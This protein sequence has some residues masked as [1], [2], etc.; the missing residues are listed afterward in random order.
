LGRR[1]A[2]PSAWQP[3]E[4]APKDG[5][6]ILI[7]TPT[8]IVEAWF[9]KGQ[10][11]E[12]TPYSEAEYEGAVWVCYDDKF[13]IEIEESET[14]Y[15]SEAT[16]WDAHSGLGDQMNFSQLLQEASLVDPTD[17]IA[18]SV[19]VWRYAPGIASNA[20][21]P[22]QWRLWSSKLHTSF[23]SQ[24]PENALAQYKLAAASREFSEPL[25]VQ[26]D[27]VDMDSA[28]A[29]KPV[30]RIPLTLKRGDWELE[31]SVA[32]VGR[33]LTSSWLLASMQKRQSSSSK[34]V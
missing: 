4:T 1:N 9:A 29:Q 2:N 12:S 23:E 24:D 30:K 22:L 33:H 5:T 13:Q 10:W 16:H 27:R 7:K 3:I 20:N 8:G 14:G 21:S 19:Q 15:T 25:E 18:I 11:T 6:A 17:T 32:T 26:M 31:N 34:R 28:P